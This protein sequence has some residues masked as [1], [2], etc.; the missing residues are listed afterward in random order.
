KEHERQTGDEPVRVVPLNP[1][2]EPVRDENGHPLTYAPGAGVPV[3]GGI[4]TEESGPK[5]PQ[6][7]GFY[8]NGK[9]SNISK[10]MSKFTEAEISE[11]IAAANKPINSQGLSAAARAWEKHAGRSG[12]TF[13][14]L[15]GNPT[16]KNI[17]A[18]GFIRDV[19]NNPHTVR[20]E[21]S[22]GG[23]DYRLPS[24]QGVR[25]NSDGSFN[26]LLDPP[27]KK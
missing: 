4:E 3:R 11:R 12:G 23:V 27:E 24:G 16:Q 15:S 2:M 25:F 18:E 21:L 8:P 20:N 14:P 9:S 5:I 19:L 7:N 13:E 6:T 10:N 17:A 26:T 22:R 1:G